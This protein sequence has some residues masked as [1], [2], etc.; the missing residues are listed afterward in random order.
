MPPLCSLQGQLHS[1]EHQGRIYLSETSPLEKQLEV[2]NPL[3]GIYTL[4]PL[5]LCCKLYY[6]SV[7]FIVDN[8]L[9]AID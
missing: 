9:Y 3:T 1:R 8:K 5:K 7:S 6:V 4:L 2:L